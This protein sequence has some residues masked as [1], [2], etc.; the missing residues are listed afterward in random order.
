MTMSFAWHGPMVRGREWLKDK[1]T[2]RGPRAYGDTHEVALG[3]VAGAPPCRVLDLGAG[4]GELS[5]RLAAL[6][7][8]VTAVELFTPQ[9][10]AAVPLV[11]A[12]LNRPLPFEDGSFDVVMGVEIIEHLE[13]PRHFLREIGR[14]LVAGGVSVVSTPNITSYLSRLLFLASGQ[15]DLFWNHP[16]RLRD[17]FSAEVEGHISPLPAWLLRHHAA[18]AGFSVD[19]V[20]YSRAWLPLVPFWLNPLPSTAGFGR[21]LIAR[22]RKRAAPP[23]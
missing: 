17:P 19:A 10:N 1:M 8:R 21:I 4:R 18:D 13:S 15:W 12:D 20:G 11:T 6:G 16:F 14:V 2:R 9:F 23:A 3:L 22:L 7:H 5:A